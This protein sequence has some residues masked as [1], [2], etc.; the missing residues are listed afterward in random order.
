MKNIYKEHYE[1]SSEKEATERWK[2]L[3]EKGYSASE[4]Y[5]FNYHGKD[6]NFHREIFVFS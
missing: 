6:G 4:I 5:Q 1:V 2:Y 3:R